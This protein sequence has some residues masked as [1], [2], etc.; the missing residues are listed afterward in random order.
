MVKTIQEH[1]GV[2]EYVEFPGEGHG[3]RKK[4][5]I[6]KALEDELAYYVKAFK[7]NPGA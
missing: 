5:T 2:V 7:L 3:W 4:E 6:Q 1:G